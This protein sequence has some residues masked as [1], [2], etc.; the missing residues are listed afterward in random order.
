MKH[1]IILAAILLCGIAPA[2]SQPGP[3]AADQRLFEQP[4]VSP[5]WEVNSTDVLWIAPGHR[6]MFLWADVSDPDQRQRLI[7]FLEAVRATGVELFLQYD[8]AAGELDRE[9]G[10]LAYPLCRLRVRDFSLHV[11]S[12]C[13]TTPAPRPKTPDQALA[14]GLAHMRAR[15]SM[16]AKQLLERADEIGEPLARTLLL[17]TRAMNHIGL[18]LDHDEGSLAADEALMGALGDYS[19]LAKLEPDNS[20]VQDDIAETFEFLGAYDEARAVLKAIIDRWPEETVQTEISLAALDRVTGNYSASL[21]RLD[22]L[23]ARYGLRDGVRFLYNRGWTL[24]HLNR[25]QE[26][27][28]TLSK[29]VEGQPDY[30]PVYLRRSC[31]YAMLG[32]AAEA[33]ADLE[34]AISL[35]LRLP[36]ASVSRTVPRDTA[37]AQEAIAVLKRQIKRKEKRPSPELCEGY[38]LRHGK[39]RD[40]SPLLPIQDQ[41]LP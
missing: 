25:A 13:A 41:L 34:T 36:D 39:K 6:G 18:S 12:K 31:G 23:T 26:A 32:R 15:N 7:A 14:L 2:R 22:G 17:R 4:S 35:M 11:N 19:A 40:R 9:Q 10:T 27:V 33:A 28:E 38:A 3:A 8:A 16:L 20:S 1:R 29:A 5:G 30:H 37:R 24:L 21:E